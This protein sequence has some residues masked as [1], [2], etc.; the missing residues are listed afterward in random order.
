MI[1][2]FYFIL[3][4]IQYVYIGKSNRLECESEVSMLF[5]N[6]NCPYQDKQCSFDDVYQPSIDNTYFLAFSNYHY[7][8]GNTARLLNIEQDF[9]LETFRNATY[10]ICS[11]TFDEL[12]NLNTINNAQLKEKFI[13]NQ[14]FSN[15]FI[16]TILSRYG[17]KNFDNFK[18]TD[19]VKK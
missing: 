18:S 14:C 3:K 16:L 13:I 7:A 15:M 5:P 11:S 4:Y 17:F 12:L 8:F 2:I 6:S 10:F 1:I 9:D 19:N